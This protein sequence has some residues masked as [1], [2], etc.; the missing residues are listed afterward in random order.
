[1]DRVR[2]NLRLINI[3]TQ[4]PDIVGYRCYMINVNTLF[5]H[6]GWIDVN[7]TSQC[8]DEPSIRLRAWELGSLEAPKWQNDA[9][10][11]HK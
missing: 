1:M 7:D 4:Y 11:S 6:Q 10:Y 3:A 9:Q 8:S 2:D 5:N